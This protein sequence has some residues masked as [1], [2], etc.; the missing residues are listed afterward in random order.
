MKNEY[1]QRSRVMCYWDM[2]EVKTVK[3]TEKKKEKKRKNGKIIKGN[4]KMKIRG[5]KK[6]AKEDKLCSYHKWI[7]NVRWGKK[8]NRLK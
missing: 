8:K 1:Q 4:K 5:R 2:A 7:L 3:T 6:T